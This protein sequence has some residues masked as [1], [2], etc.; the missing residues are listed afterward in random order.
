MRSKKGRNGN[1]DT[2]PKRLKPQIKI[3][4]I[5][6]IRGGLQLCLF[7]SLFFILLLTRA[8]ESI[9]QILQ[10]SHAYR[11]FL[12]SFTHL[13]VRKFLPVTWLTH[14]VHLEYLYLLTSLTHRSLL[15]KPSSLFISVLCFI[16]FLV[17]E[18][19]IIETRTKETY[20]ITYYWVFN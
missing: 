2:L 6:K 1:V 14:R 4:C 17:P 18:A 19:L 12:T 10:Y 3:L 13:S 16:L 7:I 20:D 5:S 15:K 9:S 8:N 11:A